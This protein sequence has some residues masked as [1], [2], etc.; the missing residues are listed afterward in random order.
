MELDP[1]LTD[2][3]IGYGPLANDTGADIFNFYQ[4]W[5]ESNVDRGTFLATLLNKWDLLD[6]GW[7]VLE[8]ET[9]RKQLQVKKGG[10]LTSSAYQLL[11]RDDTIIA[12]SFAQLILDGSIRSIDRSRALVAVERQGMACVLEFRQ[13]QDPAQRKHALS[14]MKTALDS[15]LVC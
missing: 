14:L 1:I 8:E 15:A 2:Q 11:T 7:D 6:N 13:W 10:N 5:R 9:I 4:D 12:F 3:F